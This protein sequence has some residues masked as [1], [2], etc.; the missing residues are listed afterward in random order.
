[1]LNYFTGFVSGNYTQQSGLD[2][3]IRASIIMHFSLQ[4][5]EVK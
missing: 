4:I 1:M 2:K 5:K 3:D